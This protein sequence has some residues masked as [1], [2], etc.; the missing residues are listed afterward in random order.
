MNKKLLF[1]LFLVF[2]IIISQSV[3]GSGSK[4]VA[5]VFKA[6][7][8]IQIKRADTDSW[9]NV[10]RGFRLNS[11][12]QI[13][14]GDKSLAALLFTDDKSLMK[15]RPR[16]DVIINGERE[17]GSIAKRIFMETGA[18]FVNV[19]K[20]KSVFRLETPTGVAAVKGTSFLGEYVEKIVNGVPV[21]EFTIMAFSGIVELINEY[22]SV[23]VNAGEKAVASNTSLDKQEMTDED[24]R[25]VNELLGD[26]ED[27]KLHEIEIKY[28]DE[29]G[30]EKTMK[31]FLKSKEGNEE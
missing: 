3:T 20:Q 6:N 15:V 2:I 11:G 9:S 25:K 22:G 12:D 8:K 13:R 21:Q 27:S 14:T 26:E 10:K 1:L 24:Q 7:G 16:S 29:N 23:L 31:V 18:V 19:T 4:D 5:F 17:N 28:R 30:Q